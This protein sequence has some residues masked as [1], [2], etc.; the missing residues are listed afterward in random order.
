MAKNSGGFFS[1]GATLCVFITQHKLHESMRIYQLEIIYHT[2]EMIFYFVRETNLL[3]ET[4]E[5][6]IRRRYIIAFEYFS[7]FHRPLTWKFRN[8][9]KFSAKGVP[10]KANEKLL[11]KINL[12]YRFKWFLTVHFCTPSRLWTVQGT[13]NCCE[14]FYSCDKKQNKTWISEK[15]STASGGIIEFSF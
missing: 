8:C 11:M 10:P 2:R 15:E 6:C 5:N 9:G 4:S 3:E 12:F 13:P 14:W 1:A 7:W